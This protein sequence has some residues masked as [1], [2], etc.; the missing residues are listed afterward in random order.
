MNPALMGINHGIWRRALRP[1]QP[2]KFAFFLIADAA[3]VLAS[4][5]ASFFIRFDFARGVSYYQFT[6]PAIPLF[7]GVKLSAFGF[8]Q[9]YSLSWRFV[10][11]RDLYNIARAVLVSSLALV[12]I[13]YFFHIRMFAGFPRG[14]LLIDGILTF[15]LIA[16]LRI[17]KRA[18]LEVV[19]G[20]RYAGTGKRTII[21]GAGNTGEMVL[22]DIQRTQYT[23]F[24]PVAFL[25]DDANLIGSHLHGVRVRGAISDLATV[26][27]DLRVT[28]V[29]IAIQSLDYQKLRRI[30]RH[31]RDAGVREVKIVPRL[32]DVHHPQVRL[33]AIED[34]KIEDLI[35]RQVVQVD[36]SAITGALSGKTVLVTG[37]AGSIGSEIVR[38]VCRYNPRAVILFEIDETELYRMELTLRRE[39]RELADRLHFIVG[40]VCDVD[41]IEWLFSRMHPEIVFHAAAYKHV[42]MMERHPSEAVRVNICGTWNVARA[43][44]AYLAERFVIISTDKAVRPTSVMGATKRIAEQIGRSLNDPQHTAFLSVRFGNVLG[45]RGSVLPIFLEQLQ[46]GGPLT[47]THHEMRRYFMTIP[48]AVTLVLQA[49]AMENGGDVLVLDMG[50]PVR[51]VDLAEELIKLH[52]LRPYNDIDI[53][54]IGMRPGEK[55]FEEILTAEEGTVA[56]KHQKIYVARSSDSCDAK[57]VEAL[58]HRFRELARFPDSDGRAIRQLLRECVQWYD[59]ASGA[60]RFPEAIVSHPVIVTPQRVNV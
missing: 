47:I 17:A 12:A 19:R 53:E 21:V 44:H 29:I 13:I 56:T 49:G 45:S 46:R 26:I 42:P 37:A 34:I 16:T 41:R 24:A 23:V 48:E 50:D 5:V 35:R 20:G 38:Q 28:A 14:I 33:Q 32:Y 57:D 11:L 59:T 40:D 43:A 60:K 15:V 51:I 39:F 1:S 58:V 6:L 18:A 7:L 10:S 30:Y 27:R 31:A 36:D 2:K 22:R 52:G 54:Y 55:L 3:I 4:L 8:F 9:L 25:D